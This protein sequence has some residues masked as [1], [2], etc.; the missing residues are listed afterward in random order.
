LEEKT[1]S[2]Y[3]LNERVIPIEE[4]TT[5]YFFDLQKTYTE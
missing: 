1:I 5:K 2:E 3:T 4:M